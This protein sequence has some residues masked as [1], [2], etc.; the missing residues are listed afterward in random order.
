[1]GPARQLAEGRSPHD[2]PPPEAVRD[3]KRE[4]GLSKADSG[5]REGRLHINLR[6]QPLGDPRQIDARYTTIW[7]R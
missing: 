4:I 5:Y 2:D 7:A 3:E 1:V 6:R